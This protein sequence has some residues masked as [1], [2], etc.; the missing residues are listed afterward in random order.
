[1]GYIQFCTAKSKANTKPTDQRLG[2]NGMLRQGG[3]NGPCRLQSAAMIA[4]E[5]T[6]VRLL[7]CTRGADVNVRR[8]VLQSIAVRVV[9]RRLLRVG[10]V[11]RR[12]VAGGRLLLFA[13]DLP[14]VDSVPGLSRELG[15]WRT[16]VSL[17]GRTSK[18]QAGNVLPT[19]KGTFSL[20]LLS[21]SDALDVSIA[22][23]RKDLPRAY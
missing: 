3:G 17:L 12:G 11:G 21:P 13:G 2:G 15:L 5:L 23:D 9:A 16:V 20:G 8:S 10:A 4:R 14:V 6:V 22:E 19:E 1:M 18:P 7:R